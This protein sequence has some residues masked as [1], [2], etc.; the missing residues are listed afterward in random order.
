MASS[1]YCS[2]GGRLFAPWDEWL[3]YVFKNET[4]SKVF[5]EY[6]CF[7]KLNISNHLFFVQKDKVDNLSC[8]CISLPSWM[9]FLEKGD[10]QL[11]PKSG[12]YTKWKYHP[13][14]SCQPKGSSFWPRLCQHGNTAYLNFF[15]EQVNWFFYMISNT[16]ISWFFFSETCLFF[17]LDLQILASFRQGPPPFV[18]FT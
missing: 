8:N 7:L 16:W 12:F 4:F 10:I 2:L 9:T 1:T 14:G 15:N 3:I 18:C 5:C 11:A 6:E 17:K 13:S